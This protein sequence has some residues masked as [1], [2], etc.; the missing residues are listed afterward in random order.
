MSPHQRPVSMTDSILAGRRVLIVEDEYLVATL[1]A[2]ELEEEAAAVVGP[3][4]SVPSALALVADDPDL[5]LAVLDV[6]LRGEDVYPV[7]DVLAER[8]VP[9][10]LVTGYDRTAIPDR[11]Q[12]FPILTKPIQVRSVLAAA[13]AL[14][15]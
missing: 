5:D 9:F 8:G 10:V 4:S 2:V 6:N 13:S 11:Y 7:A 12:R 14:L 15:A 1:L 3:A